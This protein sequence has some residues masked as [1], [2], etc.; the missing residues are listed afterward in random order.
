MQKWIA[1]AALAAAFAT[2]ANAQDVDEVDYSITDGK[3]GVRIEGRVF[4]ER[5]NDPEED[6][7]ISYELGSN[8]GY[9]GEIGFDFPVSSNVVVGPYV[10]YDLSNAES[11]E[12]NFCVSS[13]GYWAAGL[14][15]GLVTSEQGMVYAKLGY[16][17]QTVDVDGP[18][19]IDGTVVN[20]DESESGGGYNL[21]FGYDHSF[22]ENIYG[23]V[24]LSISESYDIYGFD[25]QRS[26]IGVSLGARF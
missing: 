10:T 17:S 16:G 13:G 4:W 3:D 23:R 18:L 21:A 22:S 19:T 15:A 1:A 7:N 14:H 25:F 12:G 9:G 2:P 26:T 6:L 5:I 24:D 20:F 8:I 11:C